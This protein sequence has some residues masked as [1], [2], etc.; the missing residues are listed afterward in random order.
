[1]PFWHGDGPGRPLAL[2]RAV[3][4][5]TRTIGGLDH[6]E[7][8]A[9]LETTYRLDGMAA[10]N[11]ARFIADEVEATGALPTDRT[12]VIER[13]RDEIGDWRLVLLSPFGSRVHAPWALAARSLLRAK[14]GSNVDVIWSDDGIM[15]RFP[16]MDQPPDP[17]TV[18][19]DPVDIE[20]TLV[21]EVAD[22]ALFTSR[23][24]E[25][26]AR[27]LL[28]PRRRPGTRTPLWLQRRRAANLLEVTKQF[29][30]F[31]I[32]LETYR[33]VLQ[34][35]FDL[36]ALTE[37]LT[38][39][40]QRRT[41][42]VDVDVDSPSPF[43]TSLMFD[44]VASFMYE[45]DAPV[46]E[47]K[48]AA[49]TLDRGLLAELLGEPEFRE[50]LDTDVIAAVEAE[51]QRLTD[52][53]KV[54]S[55]DGVHD[56]LRDIGPLD[57]V[58]IAARTDVPSGIDHTTWLDT[59]ES[60][61]RIFALKF[62]GGRK[63]VAVEDLARLRDAIGV[64]PPPGA[65]SVFLEPVPDPLGDVVGRYART[66]GPFTT[67]EA[68]ETLGLPVGPTNEVLQRLE[69]TGKVLAG[70]FRPGGTEHEWVGSDVLKRLR[71]RSLAELRHQV[72]AVE[73]SV[74]ARFL[75]H[76]QGVGRPRG[77]TIHD[78]VSQLAGVPIP[79]STFE[80]DVLG[81]RLGDAER[82]F[83]LALALGDVV[84]LGREPLGARDGRIAVYPRARFPLLVP[85]ASEAPDLG[86]RHRLVIDHLT[87]AG[88]SF[89]EDIYSGIGGGD[90]DEAVDLLW[91]LVWNGTVTNDSFAPVR[92]YT[93]RRRRTPRKGFIGSA[94]PPSAS[95]RWYL[96]ESLRTHQPCA[97]EAAVATANQLLDRYGIVVRDA[98]LS[99]GIAG[100]FSGL[101]PAL[102]SLEDI[103]SNRRGYFVEGLGGAQ[104][105]LPGAVD[106]LRTH[107]DE[108]VIVLSATDPAN[109]YGSIVPWPE[110]PGK[111]T[112]RAGARIALSNGELIAWMDPAGKR[113]L[114][115]TDD[116]GEAST[117]L[118]LLAQRH[119]KAS[120][121]E[122][123]GESAHDH[124]V[125]RSL[126][127]AGFIPG[128]K[129]F[130]VGDARRT[131]GQ[132]NGRQHRRTPH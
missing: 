85:A 37:V 21:S 68:A 27:A 129:G 103:G 65:P 31:P 11:L 25:A 8:M 91:D 94:T 13:F 97:E 12:I 60:T 57:T 17:F 50:L 38:D 71:R 119:G 82:A 24:R 120:I 43:A 87:T 107:E 72:E 47:R 104:F 102:A 62:D 26:A 29:G 54:K 6:D 132:D 81:A 121:V 36:P 110:G 98:V 78:V 89:F 67:K 64:Q 49:L 105:G 20:S 112:R 9:T 69:S 106:R 28:L 90:I 93:N 4:A 41:R 10:A 2:G 126:R 5:F 96:V 33:E 1:M 73:P 52:D 56:L 88:A 74:F 55:M 3:G 80:S 58:G 23:F 95:G 116:P 125:A 118:R 100:G 86:D 83:D 51:L 75:P 115:F 63:F 22:S 53:R 45:Y 40:E 79:A 59:L 7:A 122:I 92:A 61:G 108:S 39:I 77:T 109:V 76:W 123:D 16:D 101:Y 18:L 70:A 19:V 114:L 44:F 46:A 30:N 48:A 128:Y 15:F 14:L 32:V 34:D 84:W 127:E 117:A 42:V 124:E 99:E 35:H 130:T 66:H 113:T 131:T 111:P